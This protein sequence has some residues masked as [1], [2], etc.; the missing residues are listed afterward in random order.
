MSRPLWKRCGHGQPASYGSNEYTVQPNP[1]LIGPG[2]GH[3][4]RPLPS[5][6][7]ALGRDAAV[8]AGSAVK[9]LADAMSD[10]EVRARRVEATAALVAAH[11]ELWTSAD[12][13]FDAARQLPRA[14]TIRTP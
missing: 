6:W 8:L 1:W 13:S 4:R 7:M 3:T 2:S 10:A 11:A 5:W 12:K 14:V 9:N